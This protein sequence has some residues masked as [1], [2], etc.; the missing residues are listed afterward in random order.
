MSPSTF[1]PPDA[2]QVSQW[3]NGG[4][5]NTGSAV[6]QLLNSGQ[7]VTNNSLASNGV[8]PAD[9]ADFN[10]PPPG[11]QYYPTP[12]VPAPV[13]RAPTPAAPSYA[14]PAFSLPPVF[15]M[16]PQQSQPVAAFSARPPPPESQTDQP[17]PV[18]TAVNS[19]QA[20]ES[21]VPPKITLGLPSFATSLQ[22]AR[23][24]E[25]SL[26]GAA[27]SA[28]TTQLLLPTVRPVEI[29]P[30]AALSLST[31]LSF[32]PTSRPVE[33]SSPLQS[34]I[35]AS[36]QV[37]SGFASVSSGVVG[38]V[39][40]IGTSAL[41]GSVGVSAVLSG[42]RIPSPTPAAQSP[43]GATSVPV[44]RAPDPSSSDDLSQTPAG[45]STSRLNIQ[46]SAPA[47]QQAAGSRPTIG[48]ASQQPKASTSLLNVQ[49]PAT[50]LARDTAAQEIAAP[51]AAPTKAAPTQQ[52]QQTEAAQQTPNARAPAAAP[53]E[54]SAPAEPA[55]ETPRP[56]KASP[57]AQQTQQTTAQPK[58][59]GAAQTGA[60]QQAPAAQTTPQA[61][62]AAQNTGHA[63]SSA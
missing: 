7:L 37:Q 14:P 23:P 21:Y 42:A 29:S 30:S 19:V 20:S 3:I 17:L 26:S 59:A 25:T 33:A 44:F 12:E 55:A 13:G 2:A 41:S 57:A 45:V 60:A 6:A 38:I 32:P 9:A 31:G 61:P 28:L 47:A 62:V 58:Q 36:S 8:N 4:Y 11:S 48:V 35:R 10:P 56:A 34:Q 22:T 52:T 24:V 15:S 1:N 50:P 43:K 16:P 49:A 46:P 27:G 53:S 5:S 18:Q 54:L 40:S 39:P 63:K 51:S